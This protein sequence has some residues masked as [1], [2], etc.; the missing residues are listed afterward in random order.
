M[1]N[2]LPEHIFPHH[3]VNIEGDSFYDL[4]SVTQWYENSSNNVIAQNHPILTPAL[5]F[6]SKVFSQA[7]FVLKNKKTKKVKSDNDYINLSLIHI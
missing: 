3:E 1:Y 6:V 7:D 2:S 5:L 4:T